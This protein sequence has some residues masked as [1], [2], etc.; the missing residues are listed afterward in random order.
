MNNIEPNLLQLVIPN[1][2]S[3]IK[4]CSIDVVIN[5]HDAS[6]ATFMYLNSK[7]QPLLIVFMFCLIVLFLELLH[8]CLA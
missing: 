6:D 2:N 1:L 8:I 5:H 3:L 7:H 4:R